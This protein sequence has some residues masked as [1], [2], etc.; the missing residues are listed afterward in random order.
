MLDNLGS[1][2]IS[3]HMIMTTIQLARKFMKYLLLKNLCFFLISHKYFGIQ[4]VY[5]KDNKRYML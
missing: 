3:S 5:I 1:M 2:D 4:E